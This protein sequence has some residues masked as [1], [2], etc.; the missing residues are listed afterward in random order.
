MI[1]APNYSYITNTF[2]H[3][4][5]MEVIIKM[6]ILKTSLHIKLKKHIIKTEFN[7]PGNL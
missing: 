1:I 4:L 5:K 3:N 6:G 7:M 2:P